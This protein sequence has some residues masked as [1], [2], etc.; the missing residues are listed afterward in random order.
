[1]NER[2]YNAGVVLAATTHD[3]VYNTIEFSRTAA[4]N[5]KDATQSFGAGFKAEWTRRQAERRALKNEVPSAA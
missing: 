3:A 1:M 2:F 5:T 4:A